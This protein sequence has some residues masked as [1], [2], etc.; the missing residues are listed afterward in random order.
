MR[1]SP[2]V[3]FM[4]VLIG[5]LLGGILGEILHVMAP[6]GTIQSIFST[7]FTPGIDPPLTINLVLIKL[8][9][10][11]SVKVNILSVLG[12]FIGIYLYKHV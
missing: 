1:K 12:M 7:H 9:L 4:F 6:Q 10:G 3:L 2:W 8:V 11:F 5:G